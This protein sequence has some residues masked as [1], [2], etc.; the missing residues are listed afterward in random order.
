MP[1]IPE[2]SYAVPL[3]DQDGQLIGYSVYRKSRFGI[4]QSLVDTNGLIIDTFKSAD[5]VFTHSELLDAENDSDEAEH[6][7]RIEQNP[8][9][10]AISFGLLTGRCGVCNRRLSNPES[11]KRGIGPGCLRK[12]RRRN[13]G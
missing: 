12:L 7:R 1:D 3:S 4:K 13:K 9:E 10:F 11:Q 6:L 8:E 5:V 2:G